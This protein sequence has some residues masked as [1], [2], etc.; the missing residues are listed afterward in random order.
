[1]DWEYRGRLSAPGC[2]LENT[3]SV[4]RDGTV[5]NPVIFIQAVRIDFQLATK[6]RINPP[7]SAIAADV[8]LAEVSRNTPTP[9][10]LGAGESR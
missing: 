1:M 3:K 4:G 7:P 10:A 2:H 5:I 8:H 9:Q 6:K